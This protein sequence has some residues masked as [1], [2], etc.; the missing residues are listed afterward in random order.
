MKKPATGFR[1]I[2]GYLG[3]FLSFESALALFPLIMLAFYPQEWQCLFDFIIP[4]L[5]GV[6][7]GVGLYHSLLLKREKGRLGQREDALLLVFLWVSAI[8][9]GAL[10]FFLSQFPILNFGNENVSLGMSFSESIFEATSGYTTTGL[11]L[12]PSWA[13]LDGSLSAA[14]GMDSCST[15]AFSHVFLFHRAFMQFI[16][17]IGLVLLV[18]SIVSTKNN[19]KLYFA[20]GH[21]DQIVPNLAKSAK[22]IFAVYLG[23]V[24]FGFLA[25][26]LMGMPPFEA[27]CH[28]MC[29]LATGG[30][31]TRSESIYWFSKSMPLGEVSNL[32]YSLNNAIGIE[33]VSCILMI[34]GATNFLLHTFF[35]RGRWKDFFGD[36]EIK[37]LGFFLLFGIALSTVSCAFL[38]NDGMGNT[39]LDFLTSLRYGTYFSVTTLTT[40]GFANFPSVLYMGP[41]C[42]FVG[43]IFMT[44]GGSVGSTAGGLKLYRTAILGREFSWSLKYKD[45]SSRT[46]NPHTIKRFG[47]IKE[48]DQQTVDESRN[49]LV[50]ILLF[51]ATGAI[52]LMFVP[53]LPGLTQIEWFQRAFWEFMN[54]FS[55]EGLSHMNYVA[56]KAANPEAYVF[57]IWVLTLGMF[58]G[59]LEILPIIYAWKR[60]FT[61]P[62][63][64]WR[65]NAKKAKAIN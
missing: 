55:S 39:G 47:E 19:F 40:S 57:M 63:V 45:R 22:L 52:C 33:I 25:L 59:R 13:Y 42:I 27:I 53:T 4:A 54:A 50:L 34:A 30:F 41:V 6:L 12:F 31:S 8:I 60:L 18:T 62:L 20:E 32:A 56:Y 36:I 11:T 7:I 28:S 26:W 9:L 15:Y 17:G 58:F 21:N 46:I 24:L 38:Y 23:W 10:P 29:C 14:G 35:I 43:W 51:F 64:N 5:A 1:L 3:L 49:Y 2:F 37:T 48:V 16:G 61:D 65:K 44:I